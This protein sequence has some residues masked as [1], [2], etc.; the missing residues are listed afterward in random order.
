MIMQT[1]FFIIIPIYNTELYLSQ[2]LDSVLNQ[3]YPHFEAILIN[4]GSTDSSG[5]IAQEYV[6]KDT[7]FMLISQENCGLSQARNSGLRAAKQKWL[8]LDKEKEK[9]DSYIL[10][11]DSDDWLE[12]FA[13]KYLSENLNLYGKVDIFIQNKFYKVSRNLPI[14]Q[15]SNFFSPQLENHFFL[16]KD[17]LE[18]ILSYKIQ[19]FSTA[20][21]WICSCDFLFKVKILFIPHILFEDVPFCTELFLNSKSIYIGSYPIYNYNLSENSIM[22]NKNTRHLVKKLDS[23]F[24]LVEYFYNLQNSYEIHTQKIIL[25]RTAKWALVKTLNLLQQLGYKNATFTKTEILKYAHLLE[26]RRLLSIYFPRFYGFP[27]RMK[28]YLKSKFTR[29]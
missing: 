9:D 17:L 8:E 16:T 4:D 25:R 10:F 7:R 28:Q 3:T 26:K 6:S 27:K 14:K 11:L 21:C 24:R 12:C 20:Q 5:K 18:N 2:C 29:K 13:L 23:Y 15:T 1:K 22:R 19:Q